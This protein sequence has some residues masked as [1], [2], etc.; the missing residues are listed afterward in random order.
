M[1]NSM[2][3]EVPIDL[4][5]RRNLKLTWSACRIFEERTGISI[6]GHFQSI[7]FTLKRHGVDLGALD[8]ESTIPDAA[9]EEIMRN[10]LVGRVIALLWAGL[11][12][13]EPRLKYEYVEEHL[14]DHAPGETMDEK[15]LYVSRKLNE[16]YR[17]AKIRAK[18][19]CDGA[20][21]AGRDSD[22]PGKGPAGTR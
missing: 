19:D 9:I 3:G 2:Q 13:E 4:D 11:L 21:V 8:G 17:A 5:K 20:A 7:A 10:S 22:P 12:H 14:M 18:L 16:M 15:L 1:A 6:D